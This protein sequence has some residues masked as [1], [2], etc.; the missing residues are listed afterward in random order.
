MPRVVFIANRV[1]YP[2]D[3]RQS[4][5]VRDQVTPV[6]TGAILTVYLQL[7]SRSRVAGTRRSLLRV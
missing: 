4:Y 1:V 2:P 5:E 6:V 3:S 7:Y